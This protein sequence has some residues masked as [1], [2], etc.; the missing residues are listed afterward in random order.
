VISQHGASQ[1]AN[2]GNSIHLD[3]ETAQLDIGIGS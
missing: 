2:L 3:E 1:N